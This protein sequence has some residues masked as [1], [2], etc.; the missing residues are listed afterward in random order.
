MS[1]KV[2]VS[3]RSTDKKIA[4][5][6]LEFL[7]A[8]GFPRDEYFCS[9]LPGNDIKEK[10]PDEVKQAIDES[11]V[12]IVVLSK[13]YYDS[14][15]CLNEAG[16]IWY[17]NKHTVPIALPEIKSKDMI[18]FLDSDYKI[19]RL[20][21]S[22]DIAYIYDSICNECGIDRANI[23]VVVNELEKLN[24]KYLAY[25]E[26]RKVSTASSRKG[27]Y[28]FYTDDEKIIMYYI[29]TN[30]TRKVKKPDIINWLIQNEI[31]NVN[32]DNAFDLLSCVGKSKL[33]DD[34]LE[35]DYDVF[36]RL[37]S[38]EK[39]KIEK[40]KECVEAHTILSSEV[41]KDK[42]EKG[43]FDDEIKLFVS[44][45]VDER[46]S[47]FGDRWMAKA[48]EQSIK[49]W[50]SKNSLDSTLSENYSKCLN[51]FYHSGF[52]YESEWTKEGNPRQFTLYNSLKSL[53]FKCPFV[54]MDE[55]KK[56]KDEHTFDFDLPF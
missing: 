53:M 32:I 10:I 2:F 26:S 15:Y 55:L 18:G 31:K 12:N 22:D 1:Y 41:F 49:D 6:L 13:D 23:S 44:Y 29:V 28:K 50:E 35:L 33:F 9:S 14:A 8:L 27:E 19:R 40:L 17:R 24:E 46:I 20:D 39:E 45:I 47:Y 56:I 37:I 7:V 21:S 34:V 36:N 38:I 3:H 42:W 4:E 52:V 51:L 25:L 11:V 54:Y 43:E 30:Q 16:V 48:Q 5:M